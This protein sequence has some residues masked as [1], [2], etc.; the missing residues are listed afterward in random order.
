MV[1]Q[2]NNSLFCR[3]TKLLILAYNGHY[4]EKLKEEE[5][6]ISGETAGFVR[7]FE[8]CLEAGPQLILQL[9]I[10]MQVDQGISQGSIN[11]K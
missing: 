8:A 3:Y 2:D 5:V 1:W 10:T 7:L 11:G 4:R 9:Y 6:M